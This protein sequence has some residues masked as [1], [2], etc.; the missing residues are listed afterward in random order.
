MVYGLQKSLLNLIK[1]RDSILC[2]Q[3]G[4]GSYDSTEFRRG[5]RQGSL[6]HLH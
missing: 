6:G 4:R 3:M 1:H 5:P 2:I